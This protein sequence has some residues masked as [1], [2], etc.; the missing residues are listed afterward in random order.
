MAFVALAAAQLTMKGRSGK[1]YNLPFTK[2]TAVGFASFTQDGQTFWICPEDVFIA[3]GY[4]GDAVNAADYL[5]VYLDSQQKVQLRIYEKGVNAATT[6]PRL[7]PSGWIKAG[8]QISLYHY[9][10]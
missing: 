5:D 4:I 9:S 8:T 10:A 3:D 2:A 6:V 1:F 7:A